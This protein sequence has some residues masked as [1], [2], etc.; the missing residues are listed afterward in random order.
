MLVGI[1]PKMEWGSCDKDVCDEDGNCHV[2]YSAESLDP[3]MVSKHVISWVDKA[4]CKCQTNELGNVA[5]SNVQYRRNAKG[6]YN[7]DGEF[8]VPPE[9][10]AHKYENEI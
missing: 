2:G 6:K 10:L 4:H 3:F 7:V 1:N 9:T 5:T 8:M